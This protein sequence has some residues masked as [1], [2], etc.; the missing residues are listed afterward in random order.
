[1]RCKACGLDHDIT[2]SEMRHDVYDCNRALK[3]QLA[4]M[5]KALE[6]AVRGLA[7]AGAALRYHDHHPIGDKECTGCAY[8]R[9]TWTHHKSTTLAL[10]DTSSLDEKVGS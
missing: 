3:A 5:H 4:K 8:E 2:S 1:M 10:A 7:N 6:E 9:E